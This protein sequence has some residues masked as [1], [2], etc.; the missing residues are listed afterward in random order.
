MSSEICIRGLTNFQTVRDANTA[1]LAESFAADLEEQL[2]GKPWLVVARFDRRY[3]DA[4]RSVEE[5]Y[6]SEKAKPLY[7]AYHAALAGACKAVKEKHGRGLLLDLHGQGEFKDAICRGTRNGKTVSLLVDRDGR[8]AL[9]GRRSVLG[10]LQR[11]GYRVLPACDADEKVKEEAKF[12]GGYIVDTYGSHTGY[13]ID[14]IQIE[15]GTTLRAKDRLATT[16]RDLAT[17]VTV[18]HDEYLAV[19]K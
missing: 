6:E 5:G 17:A 15:F 9:T 4:N 19:K 16:T 18:F 14:A 11:G 13:A 3:I 2:N 10:Y 12:N 1:E 7:D 8:Q